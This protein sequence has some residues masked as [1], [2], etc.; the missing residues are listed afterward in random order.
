MPPLKPA[1]AATARIDVIRTALAAGAGA[2]AAITLMLAFRRQRHQ[3]I[4]AAS[5]EHDASERRV[6]ELYTKAAE[7]LGSDQAP[8]RLAGLYALDRLAQDT[9]EL[10]QTIVDVFCAY[11]RMPYTPPHEQGRGEK[12]R[13]AQR[14]A[15][16]KGAPSSGPAGDRDPYEE[17]QVRLTAQCILANHLGYAPPPQGRADPH[18]RYWPAT[19]LDLTGAALVGFNLDGCRIGEAQFGGATFTGVAQFG[20]ATFTGDAWFGGATFTGAAQFGGATFTSDAWFGIRG[21]TG[22][23][24]WGT[25][26]DHPWFRGATFT[27]DARFDGAT[28]TGDAWFGGA[29][30]TGAAQFGGAT[31]TGDAQFGGARGAE[32]VEL[33][34][35]RVLRP[36]AGHAWPPGWKLVAETDGEVVL[37]RE[38]SAPPADARPGPQEAGPD[39][40]EAP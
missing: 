24:W 3:E 8:V 22:D 40:T 23:V 25:F 10:R 27:A 19:R 9:P 36:D 39:A 12:I 5:A 6:T 35:A 13:T 20:G 16:A 21:F 15:R 17:Y 34:G 14:A 31:F 18:A 38:P 1:Q 29:T 32:R 2:G 28:F 33:D 30:F 4:V 26:T 37:R 11:L 7:Q